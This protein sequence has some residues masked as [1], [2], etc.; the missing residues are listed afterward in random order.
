[1]CSCAYHLAREFSDL[2]KRGSLPRDILDLSRFSKGLEG[3][4]ID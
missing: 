2:V 1:M 3:L 4:H